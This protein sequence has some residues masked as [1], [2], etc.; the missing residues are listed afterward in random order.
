MRNIN[1][2]TETQTCT[3]L[4]KVYD[5]EGWRIFVVKASEV[6]PPTIQESWSMTHETKSK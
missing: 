5:R 1:K 2:W 4:R 6:I 3:L